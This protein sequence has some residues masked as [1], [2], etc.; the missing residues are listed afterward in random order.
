MNTEDLI[1][2]ILGE[3]RLI[4]VIHAVISRLKTEYDIVATSD[5]TL[6][7]TMI[8][9]GDLDIIR[10]N[11]EM[12]IDAWIET[13]EICTDLEIKK[14]IEELFGH[15][16]GHRK[17]FREMDHNLIEYIKKKGSID[18][19]IFVAFGIT[20]EYYAEKFCLIRVREVRDCIHKSVTS[21]V[22]EGKDFVKDILKSRVGPLTK[23]ISYTLSCIVPESVLRRYFSE[24]A[25]IF[26]EMKKVLEKI[27]HAN[28]TVNLVPKIIDLI[29]RLR[30]V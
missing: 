8:Y 9:D 17:Q 29:E 27:E 13:R 12:I 19:F 14:Y 15:E 26:L 7:T 3:M 24:Y 22:I 23:T 10:F 25:D 2:D 1:D 4:G 11:E 18:F 5:D 28:D 21:L 16:L 6:E 20:S 30:L